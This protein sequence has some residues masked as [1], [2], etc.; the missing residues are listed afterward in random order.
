MSCYSLRLVSVNPCR[1]GDAVA[2]SSYRS[3]IKTV[4]GP[5]DARFSV[6][7]T[8]QPNVR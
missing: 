8:C 2:V 3:F 1:E 7:V 6:S 4:A 5:A